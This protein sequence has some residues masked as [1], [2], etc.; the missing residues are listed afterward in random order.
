ME[1]SVILIDTSILIDYFRKEKKDKTI[2]YNLSQDYNFSISSIT[3]FEFLSGFKDKDLE[4]ARE[5]L[6]DIVVIPFD[7]GCA[8]IASDIYKD[9]KANNLLIE[10]PD[11]FYSCNCHI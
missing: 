8:K 4:F 9:L 1:N 11:I 2:L 10:P 3:E 5:L 7:S 6:K